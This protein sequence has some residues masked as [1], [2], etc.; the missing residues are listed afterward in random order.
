MPQI[1]DNTK[2]REAIDSIEGGE[3][4]GQ[5]MELD[6]YQLNEVLTVV[7]QDSASGKQHP[8]LYIKTGEWNAGEQPCWKGFACH[9][10]QHESIVCPDS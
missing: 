3:K 10:Q 4:S 2:L 6:N 7:K 8:W 1:T 5:I 9:D